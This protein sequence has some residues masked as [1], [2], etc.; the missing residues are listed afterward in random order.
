[1]NHRIFQD[2]QFDYFCFL[3]KRQGLPNLLCIIFVLRIRYNVA[4]DLLR[5]NYNAFFF[6]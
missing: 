2:I 1:M 4:Q 5:T 6:I 3:I